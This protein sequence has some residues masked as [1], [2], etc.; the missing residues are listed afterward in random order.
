MVLDE[1]RLIINYW[2]SASRI[3]NKGSIIQPR[4]VLRQSYLAAAE[5]WTFGTFGKYLSSSLSVILLWT[6]YGYCTPIGWCWNLHQPKCE[7]LLVHVGSTIF[8]CKKMMKI[9]H[10]MDHSCFFFWGNHQI[11]GGHHDMDSGMSHPCW[12]NW[13]QLLLPSTRVPPAWRLQMPWPSPSR[14]EDHYSRGWLQRD[15]AQSPDTQIMTTAVKQRNTFKDV[16]TS[17]GNED[18]DPLLIWVPMYS[19]HNWT[20][21]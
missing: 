3:A 1:S 17:F 20:R 15:Y 7:W 2:L 14:K 9:N 8:P 4:L 10:M 19:T 5:H 21:R 18:A 16:C 13:R 6:S 12:G 11:L